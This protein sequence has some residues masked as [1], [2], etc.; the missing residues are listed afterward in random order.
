MILRALLIY[1][2]V[3]ET[4]REGNAR[5]VFRKRI[6]NKVLTP[7]EMDLSPL[8]PPESLL[9]DCDYRFIELDLKELRAGE[10]SFAV[11]CRHYKALHNLKKGF[12]GFAVIKDT[13]VVGDIWRVTPSEL[14]RR[15]V[16]T[17]LNMLGIDCG[18]DEA[19]AFDMYIDPESRG[20]NLAVPLMRFLHSTL[21][22][23]GCQKVY[24]F[25][26]DDNLPAMWVHRVLEFKELPKRL[27]RRFFC[28]TKS[29]EIMHPSPSLKQNH[30]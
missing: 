13:K 7:V 9:Q 12:R 14:G 11:P 29:D 6:F 4:L 30:L 1:H 10:L 26:W 27:V 25:Y 2:Q 22:N 8:L 17:D 23:E 20:K 15:V 5:D 16:H 21:K 18:E 24:G 28:F 3:R 19:Y